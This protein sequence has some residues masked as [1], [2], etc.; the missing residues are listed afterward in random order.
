L[1]KRNDA[2][3]LG[4]VSNYLSASG[5]VNVP[6]RTFSV[7]PGNDSISLGQNAATLVADV[8]LLSFGHFLIQNSLILSEINTFQMHKQPD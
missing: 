8:G 2:S 7:P 6:Q 1:S 5:T 3:T 4:R